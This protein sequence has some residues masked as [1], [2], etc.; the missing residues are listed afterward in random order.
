MTCFSESLGNTTCGAL[1]FTCLCHDEPFLHIASV[2]VLDK[3]STL[4]S[5]GTQM[6]DLSLLHVTGAWTTTD[7]LAL[8]RRDEVHE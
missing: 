8:Y 4:E 1:D 6:D 5:L 2:C 3:C 7:L